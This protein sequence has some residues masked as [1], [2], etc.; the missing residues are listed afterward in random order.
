M[1]ALQYTE[2]DP[3]GQPTG[4]AATIHG[5][6]VEPMGYEELLYRALDR[7]APFTLR[8]L[9]STVVESNFEGMPVGHTGVLETP[10]DPD[11]TSR[12]LG[13]V[14]GGWLPAGLA[15]RDG[16]VILPD[17]CTLT[18]LLGRFSLER[19]SELVQDFGDWVNTPAARINPVL[20]A[21]EGNQRRFPSPVDIKMQMEKNVRLFRELLPQAVVI[22][23]APEMLDAIERFSEEQRESSAKTI[24]FLLAVA[25]VLRS[26]VARS[27]LEPVLREIAGLALGCGLA[28]S[29][30]AVACAVSAAA[31][32]RGRNPA[33]RAMKFNETEYS[34]ELAYNAMADLRSLKLFATL[35]GIVPTERPML[36]TGDKDLALVWC[37]LN[38][39]QF[40]YGDG[41]PTVKS[42]P[43]EA[44]LPGVAAEIYHA[45]LTEQG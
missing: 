25:P 3:D 15:L 20:L 43:A 21:L 8:L 5:G 30:I 18:E 23:D 37:G 27:R 45:L 34:R 40:E 7:P 6:D 35:L 38:L 2:R 11:L 22:G 36:C 39:Y 12:H 32:N 13:L 42:E 29:S 31:I 28:L 44:F 14:A 4:R 16:S 41:P 10:L 33:H 17:R 1:H 26:P 19:P 24:E 9:D